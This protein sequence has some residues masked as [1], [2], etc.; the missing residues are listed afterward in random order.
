MNLGDKVIIETPK[1][2]I[3]ITGEIV[4]IENS[5]YF[6]EDSQGVVFI[7][8]NINRLKKYILNSL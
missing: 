7:E 8:N 1:S 5:K 2:I 4:H 6:I 3:P